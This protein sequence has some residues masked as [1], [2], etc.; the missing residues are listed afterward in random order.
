MIYVLLIILAA[1]V[2]LAAI[3]NSYITECEFAKVNFIE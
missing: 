1:C 3:F 2:I